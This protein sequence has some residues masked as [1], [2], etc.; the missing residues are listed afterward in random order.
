MVRYFIIILIIFGFN[1]VNCQNDTSLKELGYVVD[2]MPEYSGGDKGLTQFI[3]NN[4]IYPEQAIKDSI[5]GRVFLTFWVDTVGN[6]YD[7]KVLKG[8]RNDIDQEA[9]RIARLIQFEKPAMKRGKPFGFK[10]N[11][12]FEFKLPVK[13]ID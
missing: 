8:V 13:D 12:I 2:E 6:T 3:N 4:L 11:L 1:P 5:E 10:Y 9:L 7:P